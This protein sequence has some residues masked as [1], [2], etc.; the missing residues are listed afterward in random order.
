MYSLQFLIN[1]YQF[2]VHFHLFYACYTHFPS[3]R[4][5]FDRRNNRQCCNVSPVSRWYFKLLCIY[6]SEE[7]NQVP[8]DVIWTFPGP[9]VVRRI[10]LQ[11]TMRIQNRI[12]GNCRHHVEWNSLCV[13]NSQ[14]FLCSAATCLNA[15]EGLQ[16]ADPCPDERL[17]WL[18]LQT[19]TTLCKWLSAQNWIT[20]MENP[21]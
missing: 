2:S 15:D 3:L 14:V 12:T 1:F 8:L 4:T 11:W 16:V 19:I 5:S 10:E 18:H 20:L 21:N 17:R 13:L 6:W 7:L 9:V